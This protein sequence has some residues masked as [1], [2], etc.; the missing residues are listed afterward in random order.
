MDRCG[1][2]S[3]ACGFGS[4]PSTRT[5]LIVQPSVVTQQLLTEPLLWARHCAEAGATAVELQVESGDRVRQANDREAGKFCE[6]KM[7]YRER[8]RVE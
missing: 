2:S 4:P 6:W 5:S 3:C 1:D 8:G 7:P